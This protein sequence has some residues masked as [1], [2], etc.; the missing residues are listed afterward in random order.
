[1]KT[2]EYTPKQIL[3]RVKRDSA[4][5][6]KRFE[7]V[8]KTYEGGFSAALENPRDLEFLTPS[9]FAEKHRLRTLPQN[10]GNLAPEWDTF[11]PTGCM[12]KPIGYYNLKSVFPWISTRELEDNFDYRGHREGGVMYRN[13][14]FDMSEWTLRDIVHDGENMSAHEL[15]ATI[16][17]KFFGDAYI[18]VWDDDFS[19]DGEVL[20]K[21][22]YESAVEFAPDW[23]YS[24]KYR[25][26]G[27]TYDLRE[28]GIVRNVM[29]SGPSEDT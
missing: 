5:W 29:E 3:R 4:V 17:S 9:Q 27:A 15:R 12:D 20:Y 11:T 2:S 13:G 14:L 24:L 22:E 28:S 10:G 18:Y 16:T 25:R 21:S 8:A 7:A 26:Q 19:D 23:L 6:N 1:L